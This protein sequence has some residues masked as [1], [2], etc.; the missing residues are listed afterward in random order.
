MVV[1]SPGRQSGRDRGFPPVGTTGRFVR[2][3]ARD[4]FD[5]A[6]PAVVAF[7][8]GDAVVAPATSLRRQQPES[9]LKRRRLPAQRRCGKIAGLFFDFRRPRAC[10]EVRNVGH[11]GG[12]VGANVLRV[13]QKWRVGHGPDA[14]AV[15]VVDRA[16]H[17]DVVLRRPTVERQFYAHGGLAARRLLSGEN[18]SRRPR[19]QIA[20]QRTPSGRS[21]PNGTGRLWD[22][23]P[24]V[25]HRRSRP[26]SSGDR[27]SGSSPRSRTCCPSSSRVSFSRSAALATWLDFTSAASAELLPAHALSATKAAAPTA[28]FKNACE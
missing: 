9:L 20:G 2:M 18:S 23:S 12:N 24:P 10:R 13:G 8:D 11:R 27:R 22:C 19:H 26:R 3:P 17:D 15:A 6:V 28:I 1:S 21:N 4:D 5:H 16:R 25:S 14:E 7:A